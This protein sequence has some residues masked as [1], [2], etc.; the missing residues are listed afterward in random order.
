MVAPLVAQRNLGGASHFGLQAKRVPRAVVDVALIL[1][2]YAKLDV[3]ICQHGALSSARAAK[4]IF[5]REVRCF[6]WRAGRDCAELGA[7]GDERGA[8]C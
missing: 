6:A 4:G 3:I 5:N 1:R 8:N 2:A 7:A